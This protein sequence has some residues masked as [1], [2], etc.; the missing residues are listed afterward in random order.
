MAYHPKSRTV[1]WATP[2]TVFEPLH[3]EFGFT[4]DVCATAENAKCPRFYTRRDDGLSRPWRGVVWC[5]PPYG[6]QIA[7]WVRKAA[8]AALVHRAT[9]V[10]LLPGRVDTAWFHDVCLR[11]GEV[12]FYR[13][14]IYFSGA[15]RAPFPSII[16]VFRPRRLVRR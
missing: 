3:R 6:R 13:G 8:E 2:A 12:R 5:N 7:A 4:L 11:F 16:V 1:E 9:V 10:C 14:R 15:D